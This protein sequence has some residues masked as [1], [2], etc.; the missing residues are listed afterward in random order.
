MLHFGVLE[1][2]EYVS[3]VMQ[4]FFSLSMGFTKKNANSFVV[5]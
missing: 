5:S 2:C 3:L 4:I 1:I